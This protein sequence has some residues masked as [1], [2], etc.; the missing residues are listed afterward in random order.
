MST[1]RPLVVTGQQIGA[2]WT[3]ALSV[4]KALTAKAEADRI[5]GEAVFW[6]AD[7]DHD[8]LEVAATVGL[9]GR[10]RLRPH[11]FRFDA[12]PGTATGWLPWT[13]RHQAEAEA[14]WGDV[15]AASGP[16]LRSHF[17]ACGATLWARGLRAYSPTDPAPRAAIQE[18]LERW[19]AL[20]LERDLLAQAERLEQAR[21]ALP[22]D[23]RTQGAWFAL[24]PST[25]NRTRLDPGEPCPPGLWLSPGAALRPLMQQRL[26]PDTA[27][28]VLGPAER[29][30]WRLAEPLWE[31][32]GL[33]C[34]RL[35]A[36]PS[37][38]VLPAGIQLSEADLAPLRQGGWSGLATASSLPSDALRFDL[39]GRAAWGEALTKRLEDEV[40]RART[41]LARLDRRHRRDLAAARFGMD[42]ERLRQTLF[43][44]GRPQERVLPGLA[45]LRNAA[46]L[47]RLA[48][49]LAASLA[50]QAGGGGTLLVEAP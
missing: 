20:D 40:Q 24:D 28:V 25:G 7:E 10:G 34:P 46:L 32:V 23:P 30:Y 5:G 11:R 45:W 9:E 31:R 22:L 8:A 47:D 36:R 16:T 18:D 42:P 37:A 12:P 3:P 19:R 14:L 33:E 21:L 2:G 38:F 17:L 4:V 27:A 44:F 26:L 6:M 1:S 39:E 41:R 29:A 43:P 50:E 13:E 35:V 49:A 48:A 15:P